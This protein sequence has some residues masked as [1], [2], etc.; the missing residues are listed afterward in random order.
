M[1]KTFTEIIRLSKEE[2]LATAGNKVI[3]P[4]WW[5]HDDIK[6]LGKQSWFSKM[7]EDLNKNGKVSLNLMFAKFEIGGDS[8]RLDEAEEYSTAVKLLSS[9]QVVTPE[10]LLELQDEAVSGKV[11]EKR[12]VVLEGELVSQIPKRRL[13]EL[14]LGG[15]RT[16]W[17]WMSAPEV[18]DGFCPIRS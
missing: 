4:L 13:L 11:F 7:R 6:S 15:A 5:S 8:G 2:Q 9:E 10:R 18:V 1:G 3:T 16:M 12:F 14:T 17:G